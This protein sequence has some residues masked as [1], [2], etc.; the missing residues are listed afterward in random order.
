MTGSRRHCKLKSQ[1]PP[2]GTRVRLK[3]DTAIALYLIT[4]FLLLFSLFYI[5]GYPQEREQREGMGTSDSAT[6]DFN[7]K[8]WE[9]T[10]IDTLGV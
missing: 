8:T 2:F 6:S 10:S 3:L 4:D 5:T 7:N 1:S 9:N